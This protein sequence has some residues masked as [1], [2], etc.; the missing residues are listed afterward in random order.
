MIRDYR[1][2]S[3]GQKRLIEQHNWM[4]QLV[5]SRLAGSFGNFVELTQ[6]VVNP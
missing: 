3:K 6:A 1:L 2:K 5:R 4:Y